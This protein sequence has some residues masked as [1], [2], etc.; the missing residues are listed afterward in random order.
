MDEG[1]NVFPQGRNAGQI[2]IVD[3]F[4]WVKGTHNIK[5]GANLRRNRVSDFTP[6]INQ[7]GVYTFQNMTDFVNGVTNGG[8]GS[9]Y[10]QYSLRSGRTY[11]PST[12]LACTHRTSGTYRLT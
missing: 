3:D 12:T 10:T 6:E 7:F 4:S 5:I 2:G 8:T 9:G 11:P 1:F